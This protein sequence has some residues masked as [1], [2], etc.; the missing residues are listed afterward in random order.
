MHLHLR[1]NTNESHGSLVTTGSN[2]TLTMAPDDKTKIAS[3]QKGGTSASPQSSSLPLNGH[4]RA[5]PP[6]PTTTTTTTTTAAKAEDK[7][8]HESGNSNTSAESYECYIPTPPDGGWGWVIV[9]ASLV[10]NIIVDGIGYSFG[11]FLLEFSDY[12]QENKSKVSLVGSLLCGVYLF[13]GESS[14][15]WY[16]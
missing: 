7:Q 6:P 13:A 16:R 9:L 5:S 2:L 14:R 15:R 1:R 10:C 8:R 3:D 11:V 4:I 12:F